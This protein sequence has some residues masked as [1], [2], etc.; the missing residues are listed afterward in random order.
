M[1][2]GAAL[3]KNRQETH[4]DGDTVEDTDFSMKMKKE[5]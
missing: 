2:E 4:V 1:K 3:L 5:K